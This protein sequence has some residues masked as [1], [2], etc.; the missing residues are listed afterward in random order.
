MNI[1][2]SQKIGDKYREIIDDVTGLQSIL[3]N[4][5]SNIF[6]RSQIEESETLKECPSDSKSTKSESNS[7]TTFISSASNGVNSKQ[8]NT[9]VITPNSINDEDLIQKYYK[10]LR[11]ALKNCILTKKASVAFKDIA[12]NTYA[13]KILQEALVLPNLIPGYFA[14]R[15]K[16]WNKILLYGPPGV[17]KTMMCQAVANEMNAVVLWVSLADI[18][19]KYT[20]ESEKL[21]IT[22]FDMA[23]EKSPSIIIIDEMDSIGRKRSCHES[24]TERRIK[25]EFL[26]QLDGIS[27]GNDGVYVLATTNMPWE[28]DIACLR[29]F[30]RL[31]LLP[32]PDATAREDIFR[33]RIGDHPHELKP[34]DF[35]SLAKLTEGYSGSDINNVVNDAMMKPVRMLQE[36]CYFKVIKQGEIP[37]KEET[38]VYNGE[39]QNGN[40]NKNAFEEFYMPCLETDKGAIKKNF[41]DIPK[42]QIVLRKLNLTDFKESIKNVKPTVRAKFLPLYNDFLLKYGHVEQSHDLWKESKEHLDYFM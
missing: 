2:V 41:N 15:P 25:T 20:G 3:K 17:G 22:L 11:N 8:S 23:R 5:Q 16:P 39:E 14:G 42:D 4:H 32:L 40:E 10:E 12:G 38:T 28:L 31:I 37:K 33:L 7:M 35:R 26:K 24:E 1:K 30:E 13:K 29:R 34:D 36:T 18:T 6:N 21:L 27:G 9:E 19:S